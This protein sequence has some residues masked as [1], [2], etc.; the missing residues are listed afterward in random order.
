MG[1]QGDLTQQVQRQTGKSAEAQRATQKAAEED[2]K[3]LNANIPL[4]L[5]ARVK[6]YAARRGQTMTDVIEE[7]LR[8]YLPG[9]E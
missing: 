7:A 6:V 8:A 1:Q 9:A 4:S 2:T 5:H 3:R